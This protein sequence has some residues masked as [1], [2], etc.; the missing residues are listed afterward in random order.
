MGKENVQDQTLEF[1]KFSQQNFQFETNKKGHFSMNKNASKWRSSHFIL[2]IQY[3]FAL[4]C[5]RQRESRHVP[6]A[7]GK[8][9]QETY[10]DRSHQT[11]AGN[12]DKGPAGQTPAEY[13]NTKQAASEES[14]PQAWGKGTVTVK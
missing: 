9:S 8:I 6:G 10:K 7:Q 13:I 2:K 4:H 5:K 11:W 1:V 12:K 14:E 3:S